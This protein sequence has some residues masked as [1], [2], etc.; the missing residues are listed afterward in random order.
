ME[1][2]RREEIIRR[3]ESKGL[4]AKYEKCTQ[5]LS[6]FEMPFHGFKLGNKCRGYLDFLGVDAIPKRI[7]EKKEGGN[8]KDRTFTQSRKARSWS[9]AWF[10]NKEAADAWLTEQK[11][12]PKLGFKI[13]KSEIVPTDD[14]GYRV[15]VQGGEA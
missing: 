10:S 11:I 8:D 3:L 7:W 14:K 1:K 4:R 12:N 9:F 5:V 2:Y 13:E 6:H 15:S